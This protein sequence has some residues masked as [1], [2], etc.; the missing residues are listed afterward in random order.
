VPTPCLRPLSWAASPRPGGR[1][2]SRTDLALAVTRLCV[3]VSLPGATS[4]LVLA[5]MKRCHH[6]RLA[7]RRAP[8]RPAG[9]AAAPFVGGKHVSSPVVTG[10]AYD[11]I[12]SA[13]RMCRCASSAPSPPAAPDKP[14]TPL[15]RAPSGGLNTDGKYN[16]PKTT[17]QGYEICF[18]TNF[19]VRPPPQPLPPLPHMSSPF[20]TDSTPTLLLPLQKVVGSLRAGERCAVLLTQHGGDMGGRAARVTLC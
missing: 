10:I 17:K 16:G 19:L 15:P 9:A 2:S 3:P 7:A 1:A 4:S 13:G 12:Q 6:H 11:S 18:G 5:I 8:R 20:A 14:C